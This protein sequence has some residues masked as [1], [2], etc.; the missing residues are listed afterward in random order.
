[1]ATFYD[2]EKLLNMTTGSSFE[3][4]FPENFELEYTHGCG[5][6]KE[7]VKFICSSMHAWYWDDDDHCCLDYYFNEP[8]KDNWTCKLYYL[9]PESRE[10]V[11]DYIITQL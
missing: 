10:K 5:G 6:N 4:D 3:I 11:A 1:M 8:G 2:V 7:T 9:T